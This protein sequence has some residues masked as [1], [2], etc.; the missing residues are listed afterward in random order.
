MIDS[1]NDDSDD[2]E[3]PILVAVES[4]DRPPTN[5]SN[6][7]DLPPCPVTILSGFLGSGKTTL[8]Q[9]IL[10]SPDH[11]KRI[12]VI[13]NEFGEGLQV[14]SL[15]ARDGA[16]MSSL[17]DLIELP[18]GC[19]CCTVKDTLI[20]TLESLL[21][22]RKDLDYILIECSGMAN[23]GPIASLFWLDDALESRLRL[24]GIVTIV[25]AKHIN[26]QL[27]ATF[28]AAQQLAYAD[29]ILL[30]KID[31][32]HDE[33]FLEA[34]T[35]RIHGINST[36]PIRRTSFSALPDLEWVLDARSL[37]R[38]PDLP[39]PSINHS[40]DQRRHHNQ[41]NDIDGDDGAYSSNTCHLCHEVPHEHTDSV[42]TISLIEAGEVDLAKLDQWLAT[43]LWPQEEIHNISSK[44]LESRDRDAEIFRIK[45]I[46]A[47]RDDDRR[48]IVQAVHDLWEI[49]P[50]SESWGEEEVRGNKI[51]VI[52]RFLPDEALRVGLQSC[53]V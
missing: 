36:A 35:A 32:I 7:T 48:H 4:A 10:K 19:V 12:A 27:S 43:I 5:S 34:V 45:G 15:I 30:N 41:S 37:E 8:V 28:E 9:N 44:L 39:D 20:Q 22:K 13:E 51:V 16:N 31:L 52:G 14:E 18:N 26:G 6:C 1:S 42:R 53:L 50:S 11:G 21:N 24:D 29:R 33:D 49:Y 25:D 38:V 17:A 40:H 23:P 47:A 2:E 46:V 3:V